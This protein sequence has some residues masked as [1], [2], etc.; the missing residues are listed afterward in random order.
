[1]RLPLWPG[2]DTV[3]KYALGLL[4]F[5]ESLLGLTNEHVA[6][7]LCLVRC[8]WAFGFLLRGRSPICLLCRLQTWSASWLIATRNHFL[9]SSRFHQRITLMTQVRTPFYHV[10][11]TCFPVI[12]Q[13]PVTAS[14]FLSGNCST[15]I[16]CI[17]RLLTLI[18]WKGGLPQRTINQSSWRETLEADSLSDASLAWVFRST[19]VPVLLSAYGVGDCIII[20]WS[21]RA[22]KVL[23]FQIPSFLKTFII[24]SFCSSEAWGCYESE[25]SLVL[26]IWGRNLVPFEVLSTVSEELEEFTTSVPCNFCSTL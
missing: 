6:F 18:I 24:Y 23:A 1:M 14:D 12:L 5:K 19:Q 21:G 22:S 4:F 2:H 3:S 13:V 9:R 25:A 7:P 16:A 11:N 8:S 26:L 17:D 20:Y 15:T 10:S